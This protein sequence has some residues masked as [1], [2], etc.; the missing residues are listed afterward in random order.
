MEEIYF[1]KEGRDKLIN[2][3]NKLNRAV[4][5][6]MG[7]NGKNLIIPDRTNGKYKVTKDGVSGAR[8]IFFKDPIENIGAQLAKQAAEKTV[9]DAGDGT[10]TATVL[11]TAFVNNL[12]DFNSVDI[13]KAFDEIIPKVIEQLK[14]NSREL[15]HEDIKHVAS[16]S[17][18]NDLQIG[19]LIQQA[20]NH[21]DI[22]KIEESS[23]I[24]DVLD[25][26]PGMS[27]PVSYFSKHFITNQSKGTCEF[28][29]VN[30]LIIDGKLEKLEN[31]R[32]ILE[33][34]QQPNNSLLIIVEDIHEQALR[35]L[36]TFVLSQ[37]LPIC[38]I[39]SPGFS[40]HRKDLLQD[41]CDFTQS[42]LITD[43]SK[44]Y[45]TD[46][47]GK[48]QSCK[49]SKNN[50]I[51]VKDD[52]IDLTNKLEVLNELFKNSELTEYDKDLIKQRIEYLKGKISIIKVGGKSELEM[53]ERFDR[54]D[55]AVK[56]VACALEEGIVQGGGLALY[57]AGQNFA[58]SMK[59][60]YSPSIELEI[61]KAINAPCD[62]LAIPVLTD[63]FELNIID[64]LKVTRCA[65]LNAVSVAKTILSTEAI[66]L[67]ESEWM[68]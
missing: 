22:V 66:V 9:E 50:S 59:G 11:M 65:L 12:K 7:P 43:L 42:T 5:S 57:F 44:I 10:T 1:D 30:T 52:N 23:N 51:L 54:Y 28:T 48:L 29:N 40:K 62:I 2:G 25:T 6:T 49:I 17:A 27:L 3:V 55:D 33:L 14:L 26:L 15:K 58:K 36:E 39:K 67:N 68:E 38:V 45:N 13:N 53:K 35:K 4:S 32:T 60:L 8:E 61:L 19:E 16:I 46:I 37:S 63:M 21:S 47:L 24:E 56:A 34:T 41:L 31:F 20:Y 18:N 64:P